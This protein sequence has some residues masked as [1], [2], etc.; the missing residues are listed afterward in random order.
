MQ[1]GIFLSILAS[2]LFGSMYYYTT[3]L[4]PLTGEEIYGWRMLLTLPVMTLFLIGTK[5][6]GL[7]RSIALR[8]RNEWRLYLVLPASSLLLGIQL[9]LFLWAPLH[10][11]AMNVSLGYFMMPLVMVLIGRLYYK[12]KLS[13]LQKLAV[14]MAALGVINAVFQAGGFAWTSL[15][16]CLGYPYYFV[17][18]SKFKIDNLGGLWFDMLLMSPLALYFA[19][20]G[21]GLEQMTGLQ[22]QL[23]LLILLLGVLSASAL[24]S[25]I[26][27][28]KMLSFS[29]FG[30]LGYVEPVLL[31]IVAFVIGETIAAQEW[32]TYLAIWLSLS[33]LALEGTYKM[34]RQPME[35]CP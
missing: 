29:L 11:H 2:V 31:V 3:L 28:S 16:V 26:L 33:V 14:L 25:Y 20:S 34:R 30:L 4:E 19:L 23:P 6:W 12:D 32:P 17:L 9:W 18:R 5:D 1:K 7:V 15:V 8:L 13:S 10:G 21:E 35:T 27:A 22:I 24:I